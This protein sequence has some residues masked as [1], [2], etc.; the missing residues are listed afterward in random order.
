MMKYSM[1]ESALSQL[2]QMTTVVVDSGDL[3][4]IEQFRPLDAT[5][6]PSLITAAANQPQN[7]QLIEDAYAQ[8]KTEG[9]ASDALIERTIDILTV[10]LGVEILKLIKGRVSTEVDA[11]LSY[12]TQAT[13]AK[14]KELLALYA[15]YGVSADRI[16]I[17][18]ASTWEGIQAAK[19]LQSEGIDC[20]LTLLFGLHQA[21][22]CADADVKLISP[23]VGRI[24]DW[25]KK[26]E[27]VSDYPIEKDPGVLSVK[28]IYTYYKTHGIPTEI[29]GASFRST[30]QVLG[31]AGCDL[32]TIS[33]SILA[34]L[35]KE[36]TPV[37]K[38]LSVP[39]SATQ[40]T[41][42]INETEFKQQLEHDL[43]AFQLLQSGIDG[44]IKARE[45]LSELL[46]QSLGVSAEIKK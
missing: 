44:F 4:A 41:T 27:N 42:A 43:M 21:K 5:T 1:T 38:Q 7:L 29:M 25:Y 18:I 20:N 45:Q 30:A 36:T 16:L 46:H 19:I 13:V 2:N 26:A 39:T 24:L 12:D 11:S 9:Y 17:K 22:A 34:D 10:K 33:P 37:E 31:L 32:L 15:S 8:A 40:T 23:F 3:L 35:E 14:A 6:N 28:E